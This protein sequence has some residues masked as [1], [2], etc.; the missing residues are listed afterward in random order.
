MSLPPAGP[1][2]LATRPANIDTGPNLPHT[3]GLPTIPKESV[4][5]YFNNKH[6]ET[7][8]LI[9]PISAAEIR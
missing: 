2:A 4:A 3:A 5:P 6:E 8:F 1:T 9:F 7:N